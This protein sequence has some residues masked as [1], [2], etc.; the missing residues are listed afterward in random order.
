MGTHLR[1]REVIHSP[2]ERYVRIVGSK[3]N[4]PRIG[5]SS[6]SRAIEGENALLLMPTL[7]S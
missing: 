5:K 6:K 3:Q 7:I 4:A 1:A 2:R